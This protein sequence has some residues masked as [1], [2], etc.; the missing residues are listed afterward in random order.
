MG[1]DW[2]KLVRVFEKAVVRIV[3][4]DAQLHDIERPRSRATTSERLRSDID[5]FVREFRKSSRLLNLAENGKLSVALVGRYLRSIHYLL[6][7]TPIHL[8]RAEQ[9]AQTLG[10]QDLAAYYA[11]KKTEETGHDRWAESDISLL[12][13][14]FGVIVSDD[15]TPA[16][17]SIVEAN[18]RV[19]E[20][21]PFHYLAYILFAEY[22]MIVLGP[23]WIR[24]LSEKCGVPASHMSA[25]GNHVELDKDHVE[26]GCAEIDALV[27]TDQAEPL[28]IALRGMMERFSV[29]CDSLCDAG[30]AVA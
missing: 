21:S 17:I 2:W 30:F 9:R 26:E 29:F 20:E 4:E 8:S 16:M 10:H 24:A 3:V 12:S 1:W 22:L 27:A 5:D 23:E 6:R 18:S 7:H 11:A 15:P 19:I 25:I 13:K 28:R 14:T